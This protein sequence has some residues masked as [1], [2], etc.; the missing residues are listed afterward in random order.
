MSPSRPGRT[1][2]EGSTASPEAEIAL[3]AQQYE[4]DLRTSSVHPLDP[5]DYL[6]SDPEVRTPALLALLRVDLALRWQASDRVPVEWYRD[7]Y[8]ELDHEALVN[9]IYEEYCLREESGESP[10]AAEYDRRFPD[11]AASFRGV[12]EIHAAIGQDHVPAGRAASPLEAPLPEVGDTIAGFRLVEELGRGSFAR[13]FLAEELQLAGRAVAMKATRTGSRE[14]QTLA[15]LQHTHIVPVYSYRTDPGTGLHLLCM[16]YLGRLTLAQVLSDPA[17]RTARSGA[18]LA[19]LLD[20]LQARHRAAAAGE[21]PRSESESGPESGPERFVSRSALARWSFARVIAWWGARLAEALQHAHDRGVLHRDVKPSNIL[22]TDDGLP[23][24]L[25]F[26]LAQEPAINSGGAVPAALGGTLAYMAPEQ[27]EALAGGSSG[28]VDVRSDLYALGVVLYEC[29]VRGERMFALPAEASSLTEALRLAAAARRA[30]IPRLRATHPDVPPALEVVVERCLAPDPDHRYTAASELAA[31]LQAVVDDAPLR[32]ARE[33]LPSRTVRWLRRNRRRL[34]VAT[35]LVLALTVSALA[36]DRARMTEVRIA[37]EVKH[38]FNE[39]THAFDDDQM[40]LAVDHFK[41]AARLAGSDPRLK[42]WRNLALVQ[43]HRAELAKTSRKQ[44]DELFA[45]GEPLRF[46]LLG[47][48]GDPATAC[49]R[50]EAALRDFS[51]LDDTPWLQQPLIQLLD[52]PRRERLR[53]EV[54]ELLFLWMVVVA[55]DRPGDPVLARRAARICAAAATFARPVDP[56]RAMAAHHQALL[57]GKPP[58]VPPLAPTA[59][60][61]SARGCFQWALLC[62]LE[63]RREAMIAWLERAIDL[64][65]SDYWSH[66][67]LGFTHEKLGHTQRALVHYQ[68][69]VALRPGSPWAWYNRA[70]LQHTLGE[71]DESLKGLS[72]AL[73]LASSQGFDF[74]EARLNLGVVK[75]GLGDVVGARAAYEAVIAAAADG[76]LARLGR[77]NRAELDVEFGAV[78]RAWAEYD[79]LVA[80]A[81]GDLTARSARLSRALLALRLGQ[82]ARAEADLT[83]LLREDPENAVEYFATR[84]LVW[85][86]LDHPLEAEADAVDAL[87]RKPS[88]SHERLWIRTLLAAGRVNDLLWLKAP[89][90]LTVLPGG[91]P[92]LR[93]ALHGAV[94]QL[95]TWAD[96]RGAPPGTEVPPALIHRTRAVFLSALG[97]P[98]ALA[99]ASRAVALAPAA[100]AYLVRARVRHRCGDLEGAREDVE[101]G[102]A[103]EPADPHLL[104]V[105]AR[106]ETETGHARAALGL[107]DRALARNSVETLHVAKALALMALDQNEAAVAEWSLALKDDAEDPRIYL[108][109]ARALLR[110]GR[111]DR[112]AA[113]LEQAIHWTGDNL[114]LLFRITLA[115]AACLPARPDHFPRWL[116]HARRVWL[117]LVSVS[118]SGS[119]SGS[120]SRREAR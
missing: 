53:N 102:L 14:P 52:G 71:W 21:P 65:P 105:Q 70:V 41:T 94:E 114:G 16:P 80:E 108:G 96:G 36:L 3:L 73:A 38:W 68:T 119:R 76:P 17:I 7:R 101:S 39:G 2:D 32:F 83:L 45:Q 120:E 100:D 47:F 34:A 66:F 6:P 9:L 23:M 59:D 106:I 116:A 48:G 46:A 118:A 87:R 31:D 79:A 82:A 109:R 104:E 117:A 61:N 90:D 15:R 86:A 91:G 8:P 113:D 26:N 51:V 107:L 81:P 54:N 98:T 67:Y 115:S 19:L 40:D 28:W 43:S 93:A 33:P 1:W 12:L 85:L 30:R 22:V 37:A 99:E 5:R 75:Q 62:K 88:A 44:A 49:R 25:D 72:R 64:E 97:D 29:L 56:W 84:A 77:L 78:E 89:D 92:A 58:P 112:A 63:D 60:E 11:L 13:V 35:P 50:V 69:A 103:L 42:D 10:D 57:A 110:L 111:W 18:E 27:L 4:S 55:R 95:R 74:L 20:R 24:L